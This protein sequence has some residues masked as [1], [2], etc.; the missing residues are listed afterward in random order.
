MRLSETNQRLMNY[1]SSHNSQMI[2]FNIIDNDAKKDVIRTIL[3]F[4]TN[5]YS[6]RLL[7]E[8]NNRGTSFETPTI[9]QKDY[10]I[11][12][13]MLSS[14][15]QSEIYELNASFREKFGKDSQ[16]CILP[17]DVVAY[18]P[19]KLSKFYNLVFNKTLELFHKNFSA[20]N[21]EKFLENWTH[22]TEKPETDQ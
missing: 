16:Q 19:E 1:C 7:D 17:C 20:K 11:E 10:K 9:T 3:S 13:W 14:D 5:I 15:Y 2:W 6:H 12:D 18:Y 8:K 22:T 21:C 4:I